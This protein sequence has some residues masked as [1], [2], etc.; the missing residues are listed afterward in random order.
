MVACYHPIPDRM[1][2]EMGVEKCPWCGHLRVREGDYWTP[3]FKPPW[4]V[5][6]NRVLD[7]STIRS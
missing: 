4:W 1:D 5:G 2:M 7:T 6:D 3:S